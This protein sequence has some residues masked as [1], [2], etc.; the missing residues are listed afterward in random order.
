MRRTIRQ[1]GFRANPG[2]PAVQ[3]GKPPLTPLSE[4]ERKVLM[5]WFQG[6]VDLGE[7]IAHRLAHGLPFGVLPGGFVDPP[8]ASPAAASWPDGPEAA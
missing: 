3:L 1:F 4:A 7:I 2:E 5:S 6:D 8:A